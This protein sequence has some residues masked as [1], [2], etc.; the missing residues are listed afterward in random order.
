M[1]TEKGALACTGRGIVRQKYHQYA[2]IYPEKW[3]KSCGATTVRKV[4]LL[5]KS[6]LTDT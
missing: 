5:I 3:Y 1:L 4:H 6:N 2:N